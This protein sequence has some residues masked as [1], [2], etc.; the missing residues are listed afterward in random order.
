[1]KDTRLYLV[2][3]IECLDKI[4]QFTKEGKGA[5]LSNVL[6]QDAVYRNFEIIGEAAKRLPDDVRQQIP[7]VPWRQIAGFRDVLIHQYD[8]I[9]PLQVWKVIE[10]NFMGIRKNIQNHLDSLNE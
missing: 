2:H 6:I 10:N 7:D 3:I 1:M 9:D 8:G 4:E 5:F